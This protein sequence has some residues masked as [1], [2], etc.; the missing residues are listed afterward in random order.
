MLAPAVT[1]VTGVTDPVESAL[2]AAMNAMATSMA[3][4][5]ASEVV[6]LAD[7]LASL[8]RELE[9]RRSARAGNVVDLATRRRGRG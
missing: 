4:A 5:P 6:V 7:R 9:A 2:G 8:A 3:S 1:S